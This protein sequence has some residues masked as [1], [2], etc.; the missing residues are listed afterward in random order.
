M[1]KVGLLCIAVIGLTFGLYGQQDK[2]ASQSFDTYTNLNKLLDVEKYLKF[3]PWGTS[4][5][6][7]S[8]AGYR[9]NITL[10]HY[11]VESSPFIQS[12]IELS[13]YRLA[14]EGPQLI[15]YVT[16]DDL[17]YLKNTAVDKEQTLFGYAEIKQMFSTGLQPGLNFQYIYQDRMLDLSDNPSTLSSL[18]VIGHTYATKP[19]LRYEFGY[20]PKEKRRIVPWI[21]FEFPITFQDYDAPL[22]DYLEVGPKVSVGMNY[23]SKPKQKTYS[24]LSLSFEYTKRAYNNMME[25]DEDGFRIPDTHLEY[26][27]LKT[28][29]QWRHYLDE[30]C[31]WRL[32]TK[33]GFLKNLDSGAGYYDYSRYMFSEQLRY[34]DKNWEAR[35]EVKTMLY[36]YDQQPVAYGSKSLRRISNTTVNF[37]IERSLYKKLR[38]FGEFEHE[39]NNSTLTAE[40]YYVNT[41][42]GGFS[43]EF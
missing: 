2:S 17:H 32:Y 23:K 7:T 1:G 4:V 34:R 37:H 26:N 13:L 6:L 33:V 42:I 28:Q 14:L 29:L 41:V 36:E 5:L 27:Y 38:M 21:E 12:T 16:G 43:M 25:T 19:F 24:D 8:G 40:A 39:Q 10:S 3:S 31:N 30:R 20:S 18:H 9:D 35:F 22:D 15:F 11:Q